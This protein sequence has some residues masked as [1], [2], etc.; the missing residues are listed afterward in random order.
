M[1]SAN[2]RHLAKEELAR[3]ESNLESAVIIHAAS[4]YAEAVSLAYY[5]AFHAVRALLADKGRQPRSH[6]GLIHLFNT[7]FVR[8]KLVD[9]SLLSVLERA[10]QARLQADY[11]ASAAFDQ[12]ASQAEIDAARTF[13]NLAKQTLGIAP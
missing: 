3:A 13:V 10:Q 1:T 11:D 8:P 4:K 5:A 2:R 7:E 9:A 12:A 6:S